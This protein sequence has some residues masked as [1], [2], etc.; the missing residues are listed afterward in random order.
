MLEIFD[1]NLPHI[2]G[3]DLKCFE[4]VLDIVLDLEINLCTTSD[5]DIFHGH[6]ELH[7]VRNILIFIQHLP[8]EGIYTYFSNLDQHFSAILIQSS[9]STG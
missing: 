1:Q 7:L 8:N 5:Q 9:Q 6:L 4:R 3:D 2:H